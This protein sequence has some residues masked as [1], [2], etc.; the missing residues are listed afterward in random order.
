M[1]KTYKPQWKGKPYKATFCCGAD[2]IIFVRYNS[3]IQKTTIC[4]IMLLFLNGFVLNSDK[5]EALHFNQDC[6]DESN[7]KTTN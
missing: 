1:M 3:S 7:K 4:R 6:K 5:K 2:R